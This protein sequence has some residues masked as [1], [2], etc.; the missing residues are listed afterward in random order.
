MICIIAGNYKEAKNY[1]YGQDWKPDEWF[2]PVDE[3]ELMRRKDFHV[4]VVGTAGENVPA[5]YF[6]RIYQ[7]AK[8]RGRMK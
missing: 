2:Y 6:E 8:T 4:I 3:S 7:L 1:A 5:S